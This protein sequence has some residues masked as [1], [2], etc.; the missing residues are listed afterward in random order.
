MIGGFSA[1][2][3]VTVQE[4]ACLVNENIELAKS[5]ASSSH[6]ARIYAHWPSIFA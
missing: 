4:I 5:P 1:A 3:K 6:A 2:Q